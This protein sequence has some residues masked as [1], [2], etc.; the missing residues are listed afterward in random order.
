MKTLIRNTVKISKLLLLVSLASQAEV[1]SNTDTKFYEGSTTVVTVD[2]KMIGQWRSLVKRE[3]DLAYKNLREEELLID[4][5][6]YAYAES[7]QV[8][9]VES[10]NKSYGQRFFTSVYSF[11]GV[12][13]VET[14]D[15]ELAEGIFSE[16]RF[17]DRL[18]KVFLLRFRTVSEISNADYREKRAQVRWK[19]NMKG[20]G[21]T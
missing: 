14:L 13:K 9:T 17:F 6:G 4:G 11:G 1:G 5:K 7:S 15:L 10:M 2:N 18:G 3:I 8:G 12:E 20:R 21:P 19:T 16:M